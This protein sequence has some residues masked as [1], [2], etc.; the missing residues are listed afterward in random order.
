MDDNSPRL[1]YVLDGT[2][3]MLVARGIVFSATTIVLGMELSEDEVKRGFDL[4][5]YLHRQDVTKLVSGRE[6]L[7]ITLIQLWM[8]YMFAVSNNLRYNDVYGFID[9]QVTYEA[10]KF[11]DIQ[12]YLTSNFARGKEI[13]FIPYISGRS[14]ANSKKL[15]W[16]T[17]KLACIPLIGVLLGRAS[18]IRRRVTAASA[19]AAS[20]GVASAG[21]S[22]AGAASAG[23]AS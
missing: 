10:N 14:T 12:T 8:M 21:A 15:A 6:K 5:I 4:P 18:S 1:L 13:H 17:L 23:A 3:M 20:A 7:N 16:L 2:R 19:G 11:D 22:S 9:S